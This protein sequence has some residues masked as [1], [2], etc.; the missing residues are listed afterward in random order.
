MESVCISSME[1]G[2]DVMEQ[3]HRPWGHY[4]NL[5]TDIGYKVKRLVVKPNKRFSLQYHFK[6]TELW[7][8]LEGS[9][10]VLIDDEIEEA[11]VGSKYYI[12]KKQTHRITGGPKGLTII[13][14]QIGD[15]CIEEDIVRLEDDYDRI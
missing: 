6:R 4:E 10:S 9:G 11:V 12:E 1:Q 7:V 8:V 2:Y 15:E 13:E 3:F 14:V 5:F